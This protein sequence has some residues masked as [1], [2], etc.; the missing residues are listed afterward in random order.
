M[1][2]SQMN[3]NINAKVIR[4]SVSIDESKNAIVISWETEN[5]FRL[6][7]PDVEYI[8]SWNHVLSSSEMAREL[9]QML[10]DQADILD[11]Q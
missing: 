9:A 7:S 8:V 5:N 6:E 4:P 3:I 11:N 2:P 10:L 1:N